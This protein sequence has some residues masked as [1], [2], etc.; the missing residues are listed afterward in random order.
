MDISILTANWQ[1]LALYSLAMMAIGGWA[2]G[3]LTFRQNLAIAQASSVS[4]ARR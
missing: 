3:Y 1:N 4:F 2:V